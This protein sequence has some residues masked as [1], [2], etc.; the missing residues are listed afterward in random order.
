MSC[1][2]RHLC[3]FG[4]RPMLDC[5]I[6]LGDFNGTLLALF[7]SHLLLHHVDTAYDRIIIALRHVAKRY[8]LLYPS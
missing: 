2:L 4:R 7:C 6:Y 8:L 3:Y 1:P 5:I